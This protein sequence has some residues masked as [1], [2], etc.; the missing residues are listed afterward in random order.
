VTFPVNV[1]VNQ[2]FLVSLPVGQ[3]K[4]VIAQV[5]GAFFFQNLTAWTIPVFK[6]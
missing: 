5:S 4:F 3:Y 2:P 1:V 6:L